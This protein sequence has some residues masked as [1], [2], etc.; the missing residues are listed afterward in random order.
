MAEQ[1][2]SLLPFYK[3]WDTYQDLVIK[4]LEPLSRDQLALRPA[5]QLRSIGENTAHIVGKR[6]G[7]LYYT[8]ES[9]YNHLV[10]LASQPP[11]SAAELVKA[12]ES[13]CQSIRLSLPAV[14]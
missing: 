5:P 6:A 14:T 3:G 4:A 9:G 12:L 11:A 7:W 8:L 1:Q 10:S 2:I 13:P